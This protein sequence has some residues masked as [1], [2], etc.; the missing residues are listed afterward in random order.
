MPAWTQNLKS[1]FGR[2]G[3]GS[4]HALKP[5][6]PSHE[7]ASVP[8][9]INTR[10][11]NFAVGNG[12]ADYGA[13]WSRFGAGTWEPET[14][15]LMDRLLHPGVRFV[16]IGAWIGP[17]ALYA[18]AKGA[19]VDA[20]ECDPV[21]LGRLKYNISVNPALKRRIEVHEFAIGDAERELQV[22]SGQLGNSETS[23]FASHE[24]EGVVRTCSQSVFVKMRDAA[25]VFQERGYAQAPSTLIKIDTEGAEFRIVPRLAEIIAGSRA[26]WYISFHELN[27]NSTS[28]PV[29]FARIAEML[30]ALM[31]FSDLNWYSSSLTALD[32]AA[33]LD[34][35]LH[36][37]WPPHG[38]LVFSSQCLAQ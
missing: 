36:G 1:W 12:S 38:S 7:T 28:V 8:R 22:W 20:Y 17:T 18:A 21:A 9:W 5:A 25:Q 35:V 11:V 3:A 23:P 2:V 31:V 37:T 33:T 32:K 10:G 14:L 19:A 24:R 15:A 26:V 34:A 29:T 6:A 27:I 4:E 16:D 13:F 30:H